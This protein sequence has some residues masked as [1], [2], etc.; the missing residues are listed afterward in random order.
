MRRIEN[1][2]DANASKVKN[3]LF[4]GFDFNGLYRR[5]IKK[6]PFFIY[7]GFP[8][9]SV[10]GKTSKVTTKNSVMGIRRG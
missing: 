10:F 8:R 3:H 6:L 5:V 1:I 7:R 4:G 2:L 9:N